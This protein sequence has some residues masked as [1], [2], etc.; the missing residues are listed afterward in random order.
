M[1]RLMNV[2]A[3]LSGLLIVLVLLSIRRAHIRV[4]YSGS[5]LAAGVLL[6]ALSRFRG[7]QEWIAS[8]LGLTDAPLA[9]L[10]V[11]GSLFLVVLYRS[12]MVLS[13]LKDSNIALA[14][15]VAILEFQIGSLDE[16]VKA[17]AR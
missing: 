11:A 2:V 9:V 7:L 16:K 14:Q 17:T 5:W 6:L 4:E 15:K 13:N 10:M 3:V 12:S 8:T 1:D